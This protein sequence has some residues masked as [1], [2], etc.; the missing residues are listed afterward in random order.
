MK[1]TTP[2]LIV[3]F[4]LSTGGTSGTD[5]THLVSVRKICGKF[6]LGQGVAMGV[7]HVYAT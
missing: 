4:G 3:S 6:V 7:I 2:K 5:S 1:Q